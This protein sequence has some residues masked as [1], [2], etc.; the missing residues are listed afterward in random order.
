MTSFPIHEGLLLSPL[1]DG[2]INLM[3]KPKLPKE[4]RCIPF[5]KGGMESSSFINGSDSM[6]SDGK[7]L[8]EKNM[9]SVEKIDHSIESKSGRD[10][11][12]RARNSSR[13]ETDLDASACDELV[14]NTLKLPILS[15]PYST[16]SDSKRG[17]E[18]RKGVIKE[19]ISSDRGEDKQIEQT[20][21]QEDGWVDKRKTSAV[22]KIQVEGKDSFTVNEVGAS[23]NR[24]GQ[25]KGEKIHEIVKPNSNVS[26]AKKNLST[27]EGMDTSRQ[28]SNKKTTSYEQEST[29]LP[30]EKEYQVP[31]EKK[32]SKGSHSTL[33]A[34]I[35]KESLK[36]CSS[37]AKTNKS[38]AESCM[39]TGEAEN[40]KSYK[41]RGRTRE[42]YTEFFGDMEEEH[43]PVDMLEAPAYKPKESDVLGKSRSAI[44]GVAKE[45][46]S[47]EKIDKL[48]MSATVPL[49]ATSPRLEN[50][51]LP[52]LAHPTQAPPG[53]DLW[54]CCDKCQ[55]WRLLPLGTSDE[56]LPEKWVCSM[57]D[58]L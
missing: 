50:G 6:K 35:P 55:K 19:N 1:H 4:G 48:S 21:T 7:F 56:G 27:T 9:K 53:K 15:N 41:D 10:K 3:D 12:A 43:T 13:K 30:L 32:K 2:F 44:N 11:D 45:R 47:A 18:S 28:K 52:D 49:R 17:K 29:R 26:K 20:F 51:H 23:S 31:G 14:S 36:V 57:L 38:A 37:M 39:N 5:P 42:T 58:W 33:A 24:E 54:V 40:G 16:T 34:G 25:Q 8:V 46:P 22:G